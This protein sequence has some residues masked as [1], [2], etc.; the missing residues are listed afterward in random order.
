MFVGYGEE[1]VLEDIKFLL[2]EEKGIVVFLGEWEFKLLLG[3]LILKELIFKC[4]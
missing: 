4:L 3:F 1:C 2:Y